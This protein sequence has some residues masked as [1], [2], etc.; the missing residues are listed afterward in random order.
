MPLRVFEPRYLTMVEDVMAGDGEFGVV[1]ISRGSEV[2]GN[3]QRTNVGTISSV[4]HDVAL[5]DDHRAVVGIGTT[6]FRVV[7]WLGED[8]Y[9]AAAVSPLADFDSPRS[10]ATALS[11]LTEKL[12]R[13]YALASELGA[14][15]S[16]Q[17]LNLP[18]DPE[19]ALWRVGSL[20]PLGQLDRQ[21]LVETTGYAKC[22]EV[23]YAL[24]DD[25]IE[26]LTLTLGTGS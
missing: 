8:P 26:H 10:D 3:D 18:E 14:D 2:G 13:V 4:I 22:L 24:A 15:V 19:E 1:L 6:R 16:H 23:L 20:L 9:P 5:G 21:R 12:V 17:D 11:L 7:E 25:T